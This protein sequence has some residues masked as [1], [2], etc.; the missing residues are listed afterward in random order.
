MTIAVECA[1]RRSK[2]LTSVDAVRMES[3]SFPD[4]VFSIKSYNTYLHTTMDS[5]DL[6]CQISVKWWF[7][8]AG[9]T[10]TWPMEKQCAGFTTFLYHWIPISQNIQCLHEECLKIL[11]IHIHPYI[12]TSG[13]SSCSSLVAFYYANVKDIVARIWQLFQNFKMATRWILQKPYGDF[14]ALQSGICHQHGV[15]KISTGL[16]LQSS[17]H[18]LESKS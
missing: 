4:K 14:Q 15:A 12:L 18:L 3:G 2:E 13:I 6:L 1:C 16:R 11:V 9:K 10:P 7:C 8:C 5:V 17:G